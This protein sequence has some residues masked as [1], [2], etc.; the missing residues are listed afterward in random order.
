MFKRLKLYLIMASLLSFVTPAI[1]QQSRTLTL[2]E[3]Y[4]PRRRFNPPS[5]AYRCLCATSY[6]YVCDSAVATVQP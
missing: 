5:D 4:S 2:D 6:Y 3:I 1:G